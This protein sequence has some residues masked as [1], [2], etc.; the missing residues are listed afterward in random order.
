MHHNEPSCKWMHHSFSSLGSKGG[1]EGCTVVLGKVI[2]NKWLSSILVHS[3]HNLPHI[4]TVVELKQASS[5][6]LIS[7]SITKTWEQRDELSAN[8]C[9][10]LILKDN[11]IQLRSWSDLES[12]SICRTRPRTSLQ[13]Y[14][15]MIAHQSLC[16]RIN[17]R[18]ISYALIIHAGNELIRD[19]RQQAQQ[20]QQI[21]QTVKYWL[22]YSLASNPAYLS[23]KF[24][25]K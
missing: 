25:P 8:W 6:D 19:G 4:S 11:C 20:Y 1:I 14:F 7:C 3:L 18:S 23:P 17:L 2:S 12:I 9:T 13:Q 10:S 21:L 5:T 22:N 24:A 16:D 15:S